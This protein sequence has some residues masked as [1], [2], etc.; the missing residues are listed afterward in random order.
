MCLQVGLREAYLGIGRRCILRLFPFRFRAVQRWH[1]HHV[2]RLGNVDLCHSRLTGLS[3]TDTTV[4]TLPGPY[5][6]I[7][8][9]LLQYC[10]R[11]DTTYSNVTFL[12]HHV[13]YYMTLDSYRLLMQLRVE[14]PGN[15]RL[16]Q[17]LNLSWTLFA[18]P[19]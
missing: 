3:D 13:T 12:L 9:V 16:D 14:L 5:C 11:P 2:I 17:T 18:H 4:T 10:Y 19:W 1:Q 7:V 15:H 6:S 8:V